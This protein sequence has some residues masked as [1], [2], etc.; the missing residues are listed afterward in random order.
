MFLRALASVQAAKLK[1][2]YLAAAFL[3]K[4]LFADTADS[5]SL[6]GTLERFG[7]VKLNRNPF[8]AVPGEY[9]FDVTGS[10]GAT[11]PAQSTFKSND[12]SS[13][14]GYLYVLDNAVTLTAT[15]QTV[16][17]RA[18]VAGL[19]SALEVADTC[20]STAPI[21]LVNVDNT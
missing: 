6:G 3:Q 10:I 21:A 9:D 11:I 20:T 13:N 8:P 12:S 19:D 2:F 4:N 17:L 5:E 1:L 14:P 18:L 15:T 7:R 16:T